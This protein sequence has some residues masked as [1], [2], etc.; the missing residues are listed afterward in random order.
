VNLMEL[1]NVGGLMH[2]DRLMHI[3]SCMN[4]VGFCAQKRVDERWLAD[5]HRW[6]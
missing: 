3:G 1:K 4:V 6:G 2:L 5:E